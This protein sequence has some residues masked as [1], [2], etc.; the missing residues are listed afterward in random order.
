MKINKISSL[1]FFVHSH[2]L[3]E[4]F[5]SERVIVHS[6]LLNFIFEKDKFPGDFFFLIFVNLT[7]IFAPVKPMPKP[8][9][10]IQISWM[11]NQVVFLLLFLTFFFWKTFKTN[12]FIFSNSYSYVIYCSY[13]EV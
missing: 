7:I 9:I 2:F 3:F 13:M 8:H 12:L 1:N 11:I 6:S 10:R 4:V 5:K